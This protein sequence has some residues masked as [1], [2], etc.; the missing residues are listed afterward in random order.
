MNRTS[1][2][3]MHWINLIGNIL[4][5]LGAGSLFRFLVKWQPEAGST[6]IIGQLSSRTIFLWA[7]MCGFV[8]LMALIG[9]VDSILR[10]SGKAKHPRRKQAGWLRFIILLFPFILWAV[11]AWKY[12]IILP[13][14]MFSSL[15]FL[16]ILIP[17]FW[18]VRMASGNLW[19]QHHGRDASVISFSS[20][21]SMPLIMLMQLLLLLIA[22]FV[23]AALNPVDFLKVPETMGEIEELLQSPL[24]I[25]ALTVFLSV[26]APVVEELFKTL[27]VWSLLGLEISDGEGYVAG[28]MSGAAFALVEGILYAAQAANGPG[29]DWLYFLLGRFGGTLIHIFNGGLIGWVLTKTWRDRNLARLLVVYILAFII[30]GVWNLAVVL[31][32]WIPS[33]RGQE[34]NMVLSSGVMVGLALLFAGAFFAFARHVLKNSKTQ[35]IVFD[36]E[37][38]DS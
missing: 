12:S 2:R 34:I 16:G 25:L 10:L 18:I 35:H 7:Y 27:A 28:M 3:W 24:I 5:V 19:G 22:I 11:E 26:I 14:W 36:G 4:V 33:I 6:A 32:Q 15:V 1:P 30:H 31:T 37:S 38:N 17:A 21:V 8:A 13:G 9:A 20:V 23:L 29:N